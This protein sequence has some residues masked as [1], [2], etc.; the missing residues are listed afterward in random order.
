MKNSSVDERDFSVSTTRD[1]DRLVVSACGSLDHF[2]VV[3]LRAA[4]SRAV[5]EGWTRIVLDLSRLDFM[6]SA[7]VHLIRDADAGRLGSAEFTMVDGSPGV[8]RPLVL[9]QEPRRLPSAEL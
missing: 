7:G 8:A 5:G 1:G 9:L 2:S 4:I 6:G 3:E